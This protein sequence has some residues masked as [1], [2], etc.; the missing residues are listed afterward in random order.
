ML[1]GSLES[2]E[3]LA[4]SSTELA[5]E[6]KQNIEN[7]LNDNLHPV[8]NRLESMFKIFLEAESATNLPAAN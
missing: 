5:S 4:R 8:M 3:S 2:M 1:I 6:I 7:L